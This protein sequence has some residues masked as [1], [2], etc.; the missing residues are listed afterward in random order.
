[1]DTIEYSDQINNNLMNIRRGLDEHSIVAIT[2]SRGI[3]TYVND[4]FVEL[5]KYERHEL[6]GKD[7]R[8][9]NSGY[10]DKQFFK[11]LWSTISS[12]EVWKGEI[13]NRAKDGTYY[14]VNTTILPLKDQ[15]GTIQEYLAIR[16]DVTEQKTQAEDLRSLLETLEQTKE[17][18]LQVERLSTKQKIESLGILVSGVAHEINTPIGIGVTAVSYLN[19]MAEE[20]NNSFKS[21]TMKKSDLEKFLTT[22]LETNKICF[23]AI[24]NV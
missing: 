20:L 5:S 19:Q 7:H 15:N 17:N 16:T 21:G 12:G 4:K 6:L 14:W 18:L 10:H 13:K 22:L 3:I 24:V 1:M 11:H 8:I 2:N 9:I 23:L